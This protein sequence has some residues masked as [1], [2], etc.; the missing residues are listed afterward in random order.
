MFTVR[1]F[2]H[3]NFL[4]I[5]NALIVFSHVFVCRPRSPW[6]NKHHFH[7]ACIL[8]LR[9]VCTARPLRA[10]GVQHL[11][12][13]HSGQQYLPSHSVSWTASLTHQDTLYISAESWAT[14]TKW[15]TVSQSF[16]LNTFISFV[17][18]FCAFEQ[19]LVIAV[20]WWYGLWEKKYFQIDHLHL[21][22]CYLDGRSGKLEEWA[23]FCKESCSKNS[24]CSTFKQQN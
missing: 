14:P 13:H 21:A 23:V 6:R 19:C 7:P 1:F 16:W 24:H 12:D 3:V 11:H 8:E 2:S 10:G 4:R 20:S 9:R 15:N 22:H 18:I 17:T 5:W